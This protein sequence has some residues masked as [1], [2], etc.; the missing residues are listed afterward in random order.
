MLCPL[1]TECHP[2]LEH[3]GLRLLGQESVEQVDWGQWQ[4]SSLLGSPGSYNSVMEA[5]TFK[6]VHMHKGRASL[7]SITY[8][9]GLE[10]G[11]QAA[12]IVTRSIPQGTLLLLFTHWLMGWNNL[13]HIH[14]PHFMLPSTPLICFF[15]FTSLW[16]G[17]GDS[18][19]LS[20][21]LW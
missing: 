7:T 8:G 5:I 14:I 4:E 13:C 15:W 1:L 20:L 21:G 6:S 2:S 18:L 10:H 11:L 9:Q 19:Q 16:V 12:L 17:G 3:W